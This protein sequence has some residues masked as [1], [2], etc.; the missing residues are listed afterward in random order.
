MDTIPQVS[1]ALQ[2]IMGE[3]ADTAARHTGFVQRQSKMG[4]SAFARTLTFGW[5]NEPDATLEQ[6]AQMASLSG[7]EISA[8]GLD[9]R[10]TPE[11]ADFMREMLAAG[12]AQVIAV[13]P[14]AIPLLQ[15]FNGVFVQDSTVIPLPAALA[16]EWAGCGNRVPG[17][18]AALKVQVRLDMSK[19][20]LE[21]PVL[22]DG[23]AHD[24][25]S[26]LQA[27]PLPA[28]ALQ[29]VDLGYFSLDKLQ[30]QDAANVYWLSR[31]QVQT[32][33]FDEN[34]R[35]RDLLELLEEQGTDQ[36]DIRIR[37]G[38]TH[39]L[40]CRLLA[41]RVP[42]EIADQRRRRLRDEARKRGQTV[43]QARLKLASWTFYIT[44]V[45]ADMLTLR[46]A[47]VLARARWQIELLFKLWKSHGRIDEWRSKKPWRILCEVYAKL[48]AMLIQHWLLVI[49]CW[50]FPNRS[51]LKA[52]QTVRK[53]VLH[54][55]C[56]LNSKQALCEAISTLQRCL[57]AGCRIN[58]RKTAPHSYQLLL[59]PD[60]GG[61]A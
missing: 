2:E 55:A 50:R 36:I 15:R 59:D 33:V 45:P 1:E 26:P 19:G 44:N 46:E 43:S 58:K 22:Q 16:D 25:T 11:A 17:H 38:A 39:Q 30:E 10:F 42:Q 13:D 41:A 3:V 5:M 7:V 35:R 12:V 52:V 14:V 6:L 40:S 9:Q 47:W 23:R 8:Q 61:L 27:V 56:H 54:L 57:A 21:G 28:G 37:V 48:L 4:G 60:L 29:L 31:L 32:A 24:R 53:H 49:S 34:G 18:E 20:A 51:L